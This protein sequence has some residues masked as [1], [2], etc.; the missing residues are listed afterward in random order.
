MLSFI[1]LGDKNTGKFT[2]CS[3][4]GQ[5]T[6]DYF[7]CNLSDFDTIVYFDIL[8][9]NEHSDHAPITFYLPLK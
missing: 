3:Q 4:L 9:F 6:V 1:L 7:L 2:F 8:S 5:S